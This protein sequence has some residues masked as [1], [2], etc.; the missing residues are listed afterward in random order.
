[1]RIKVGEGQ[2]FVNGYP[3]RTGFSLEEG[4][5]RLVSYVARRGAGCVTLSVRGGKLSVQGD[6]GLIRWGENA[7]LY[8]LEDLPV[9]TFERE[10]QGEN[11]VLRIGREIETDSGF[12]YESCRP[13]LSPVVRALNG[14]RIPL[15][16]IDG[17]TAEGEER[18]VVLSVQKG[19]EAVL[20]DVWG[21]VAA[22][23][24]DVTVTRTEGDL[25]AR[26][27]TDGYRWTGEAFE[28]TAHTVEGD[29][30]R[31]FPLEKRGRLLLEAVKAGDEREIYALTSAE[32]SD[33]SALTEYFGEIERVRDPLFHSSSTAVSAQ[34]KT[35]NGRVAVTYDFSFEGDKIDNIICLDE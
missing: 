32:L 9:R 27:I 1:M 3:V 23:G 16:K 7:E 30:A 24:N 5:T 15:L 22:S 12:R 13:I 34:K 31:D 19:K 33:L 18:L 8:P 25:R 17:R 20:L 6:I 2:F 29:Y 26:K 35:P 11:V 4:E 14:Q 10:A 28:R 21:N